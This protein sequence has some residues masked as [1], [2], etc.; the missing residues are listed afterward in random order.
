MRPSLGTLG[1]PRHRIPGGSDVADAACAWC[2]ASDCV[3]SIRT[4]GEDQYFC[5]NACER[6]HAYRAAPVLDVA[7]ETDLPPTGPKIPMRPIRQP[8]KQ[9]AADVLAG[10][11]DIGKKK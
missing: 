4:L 1:L 6:K 9:G 5:C 8:G 7:R 11:A 10:L 2:G 3:G